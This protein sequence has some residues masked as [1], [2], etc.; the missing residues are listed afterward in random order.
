MIKV[1]TVIQ[2]PPDRIEATKQILLALAE[3]TRM[4]IGVP[5]LGAAAIRA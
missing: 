2:A 1:I 3:P 5:G 4:E